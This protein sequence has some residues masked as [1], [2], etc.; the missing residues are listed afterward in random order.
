[1]FT[2]FKIRDP[3]LNDENQRGSQL[4]HVINLV[5]NIVLNEE[6]GTDESCFSNL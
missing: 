6:V 2:T 4:L 5:Q 3:V 1:M